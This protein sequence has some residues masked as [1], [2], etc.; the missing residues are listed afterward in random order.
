MKSNHVDGLVEAARNLREEAGRLRFSG[1]VTHVYNPLAYAWACHEEY[2]RRYG[3]DKKRVLFLGMNPGPFGMVQTGIPFGEIAAVR[4]W[5][6]IEKPVGKPPLEHSKRPVQG[7]ACPRSEVSGK[8]L[9]GLFADRFPRV[10]DFFA[11]HFV[12]NYCPLAFLES[13]GR[14]VTPDKLPSRERLP[15]LEICDRHLLRLVQG[16]RPD[17]IIGIGDFAKIRIGAVVPAG[18]FRVGKIAHPS[19]ANPA[20]NRGWAERVTQQ[21]QDLDVWD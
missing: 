8:R 7:F 1:R 14:N 19:P 11:D 2:I 17:W 20:A 21:L 5:L 3:T 16:L 9:W 15:L 18:D 13:S 10:T 6:N 4:D 12:A